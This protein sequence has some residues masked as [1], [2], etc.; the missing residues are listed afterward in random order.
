MTEL[1]E[2]AIN[3]VGKLPAEEQDAI[4]LRIL[5]ELTDDRE[6]ETR[7]RATTEDQWE[8]LA[9]LTR[10]EIAAGQTERLDEILSSDESP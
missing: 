6:W 8:R 4:A 1:L 10:Q 3:E 5:A 2:Q 7:F 9:E